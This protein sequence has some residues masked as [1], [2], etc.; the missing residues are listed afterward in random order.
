MG[1]NAFKIALQLPGKINVVQ[2]MEQLLNI[3]FGVYHLFNPNF[4]IKNVIDFQ[5]KKIIAIL[6]IYFGQLKKLTV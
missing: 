1:N 5:L 6:K 3:S 4:S 2:I